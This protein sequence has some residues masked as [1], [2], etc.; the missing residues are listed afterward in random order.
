MQ[1]SLEESI[2]LS[3]DDISL[4]MFITGVQK[5][6]RV[7]LKQAGRISSREQII[8][9]R[10]NGI[11]FVWVNEKLSDRHCFYKPVNQQQV[12]HH[13]EQTIPNELSH[14]QFPE[15][16]SLS[17]VE[18]GRAKELISEAKQLVQKLLVDMQDNKNVTLNDVE[19]LA[20]DMI[21]SAFINTDAL[22]CASALRNKDSYLLEHS[23]NVAC[24]LISF[25]KYLGL[26]KAIMKELAIGGIIH[27][28]G[29]IEVD[30]AILQKPAKLSPEEFEE[31]KKH[32]T[33]AE[34]IINGID[35]LSQTSRDVCLMHHEKLDGSGYPRG[36]S[37]DQISLYGKMACVVDIYDALT[38][39]RVYKDGVSP[40]E[41]FKILIRLTPY[42]LDT[43]L[44]YKFINC[45]SVYP[46]GSI[47]QLD[48]YRV[49]V[50]C[51]SNK[52]NP[53]EPIVKCFYSLSLK[54]QV[55]ITVVDLK[56]SVNVI[57]QALSPSELEKIIPNFRE[58]I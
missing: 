6:K 27:D 51:E 49:G 55:N 15:N 22:L 16:T 30:D 37:G 11:K 57:K 48:D 7:N 21:E 12:F 50:V 9:L 19:I 29:K 38:A 36:L 20:D 28:I 3:V 31:M 53:L 34:K 42:H 43:D 47:V 39:D 32:Q 23:V 18:Y 8:T 26:T 58:Y 4:G 33:H 24:L 40:L 46:A 44:V 2:K 54:E 10:E 13:E 35:G 56:N 41:A 14:T 52:S 45:L 1:Y 25:G 17:N 5:R